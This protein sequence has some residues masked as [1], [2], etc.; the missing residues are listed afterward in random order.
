MRRKL[1]DLEAELQRIRSTG[2]VREARKGFGGTIQRLRESMKMSLAELARR[3]GCS[4]ALLSRMERKDDP[5]L[6]LH[7]ISKLAAG[8]GLRVSELFEEYERD[9]PTDR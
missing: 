9:N 4:K 5:N 8:L 7:N 1:T 3:S 6:E 2:R